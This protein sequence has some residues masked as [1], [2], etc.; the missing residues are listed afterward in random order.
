MSEQEGV[1]VLK[2]NFSE[3]YQQ[4]I[5]KAGFADYSAVSGCMVIEPYG[6]AVWELIQRELDARF[7]SRGVRNAYYPMLIPK[8]L[9]EKEREHVEGFN[10]EVAWVTKAGDTPLDEQ[11][12][13]RPTSET[14]MY[15][16][17]SKKIR[18]WR[19]LP[20]KVNQWVNIVRWEFKHP[21]LFLRTR[22]FLWQE[23]HTA[24]A[25]KEEA[26]DDMKQ[27]LDDYKYVYEHLLAV[28]VTA[29]EKTQSDKFAGADYSWTLDIVM[30]DGKMIQG[31]TVHHLGQRFSRMFD[32][33]FLD[34][35]GNKK[36]VYQNS[37][38]FATRAIGAL[39]AIHGDDKG[40]ILPPRVAPIQV[41]VVPIFTSENKPEVMKYML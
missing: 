15:E 5:R 19:D 6:Y 23:G 38:G 41:V 7:K 30:P 40:A 11:L 37:W 12:A 28:P 26:E 8:H 39:I 32:I 14:I 21:K 35:S 29:G 22:E 20:Y 10:P 34:K 18:S 27:A 31:A 16:H 33:Q 4:V 36:Y 2:S 1:T 13:I 3:W 24:F 9:F 17:F 25:T